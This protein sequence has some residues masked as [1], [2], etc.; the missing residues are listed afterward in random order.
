MKD[1]KIED[2]TISIIGSIIG[3]YILLVLSGIHDPKRE[4][5]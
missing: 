1:K 5:D 4:S 3:G 2:L